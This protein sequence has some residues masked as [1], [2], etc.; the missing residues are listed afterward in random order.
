MS[1]LRELIQTSA[2]LAAATAGELNQPMAFCLTDQ[3]ITDRTDARTP[4]EMIKLVYDALSPAEFKIWY[5]GRTRNVLVS[6]YEALP[7]PEWDD[8][9]DSK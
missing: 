5:D 4:L 9:K 6:T 3:F 1:D 8:S 2:R 7:E